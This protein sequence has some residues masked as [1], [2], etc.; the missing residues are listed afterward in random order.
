MPHNSVWAVKVVEVSLYQ[1]HWGSNT[2]HS[3]SLGFRRLWFSRSGSQTQRQKESEPDRERGRGRRTTVKKNYL[4]REQQDENEEWQSDRW[5]PWQPRSMS[6]SENTKI[7]LCRDSNRSWAPNTAAATVVL[8]S[9]CFSTASGGAFST[10]LCQILKFVKALNILMLSTPV[11]P[12]LNVAQFI[13]LI[14]FGGRSS[15][16]F[17]SCKLFFICGLANFWINYWHARNATDLV[18]DRWGGPGTV[19]QF[20]VYFFA[21]QGRTFSCV[22]CGT[23]NV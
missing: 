3:G 13:F 12:L 23:H 5:K 1:L 16:G 4:S 11:A 22:L 15:M 14:L 2:N 18:A 8:K 19:K 9:N 10:P 21:T 7:S 6:V 17:F 20:V